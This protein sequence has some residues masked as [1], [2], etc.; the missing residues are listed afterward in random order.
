MLFNLAL[1]FFNTL[2][3]CLVFYQR[4][5]CLIKTNNGKAFMKMFSYQLTQMVEILR[6]EGLRGVLVCNARRNSQIKQVIPLLSPL[7]NGNPIVRF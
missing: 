4:A 3:L 2:I 1:G 7:A 5:T 6:R